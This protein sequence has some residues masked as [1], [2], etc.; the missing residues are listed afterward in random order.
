MKNGYT[1]TCSK[2][3]VNKKLIDLIYA[4]ASCHYE[5]FSE[6]SFR[7]VQIGNICIATRLLIFVP[8]DLITIASYARDFAL[9]LVTAKLLALAVLFQSVKWAR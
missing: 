2:P 6:K 4:T 9:K 8:V 3:L 1:W 7:E 5:V